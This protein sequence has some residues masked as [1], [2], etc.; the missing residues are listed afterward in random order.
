MKP[1]R[2][3]E[4]TAIAALLALLVPIMLAAALCR[5]LA[6]QLHPPVLA[7]AAA[8]LAWL[9]SLG[10]AHAAA[11]NAHIQIPVLKNCVSKKNGRR[12]ETAADCAFLLFSL[13]SL[14][15]GLV[16]LRRSLAPAGLPGHPVIYAS[17]PAGS[18]LTVFRL[19]QRLRGN[20]T[21]T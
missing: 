18:A 4:K 10:M 5:H 7:A 6:P 13:A 8:C 15:I 17:I 2:S 12:L 20:G 11:E 21:G 14:V 16:V 1:H 19:L 3:F 9:S